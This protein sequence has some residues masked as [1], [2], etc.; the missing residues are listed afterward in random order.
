M[1]RV[2]SSSPILRVFWP[3]VMELILV[4]GV[5]KFAHTGDRALTLNDAM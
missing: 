5:E 1:S 2:S 4:Y 3:M